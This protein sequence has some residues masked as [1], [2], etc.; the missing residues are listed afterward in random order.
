MRVI[1]GEFK[2]R[3]LLAPKGQ[4]TR[5]TADRVRE[6]MFS[7]LGA[8]FD[9]GTCLDLFAGSGA[10]GIEA[11]SRGVRLAVFVDRASAGTVQDNLRSLGAQTRARVLS[12]PHHAA[13]S[14][15]RREGA[16][17]DLVFLDP[18]YRL[19]LLPQTLAALVE[20]KLLCA[21]AAVVTEMDAR[22][23]VPEQPALDL[24]KMAVYGAVKVAIYTF[25]P[26]TE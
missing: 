15:L 26:Q 7:M 20:M 16:Q 5:P 2:G 11:I 13:L 3:S 19:G 22:T 9:G 14:R 25:D 8:Y 24:K 10:L 17:F 1:A 23:P 21:G 18:P 4:S 12:L 6:A